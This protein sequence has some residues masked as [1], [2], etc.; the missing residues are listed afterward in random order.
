M[1]LFFSLTSILAPILPFQSRKPDGSV[2]ALSCKSV[3]RTEENLQEREKQ[4][5]TYLFETAL[6]Y[7]PQQTCANVFS[8]SGFH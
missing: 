1:H 8:D 7:L 3:E 5:H 6:L 4:A 2:E